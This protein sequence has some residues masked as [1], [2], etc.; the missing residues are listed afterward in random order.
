MKKIEKELAKFN[1][2][3]KQVIKELV[4]KILAHKWTEL[5][6]LKLTNSKDT[7]RVKKGRIR[8]IFASVNGNIKIKSIQRRSDRTYKK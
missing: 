2:K 7:F 1:Q 5:N 6:S 3:E 8:I 4:T